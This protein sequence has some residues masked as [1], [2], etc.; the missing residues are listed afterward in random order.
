MT[1]FHIHPKQY[2]RLEP[3]RVGPRAERI[4]LSGTIY[5]IALL[6]IVFVLPDP[7]VTK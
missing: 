5:D 1:H 3:N 4:L 6:W 7:I 2:Y